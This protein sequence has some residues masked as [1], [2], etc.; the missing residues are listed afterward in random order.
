M[1]ILPTK[2]KYETFDSIINNIR[3][4][5]YRKHYWHFRTYYNIMSAP[6][7]GWNLSI[8]M[9]DLV[10]NSIEGYRL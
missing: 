1:R 5:L 9:E 4:E 7:S 10:M 6:E 3:D 8:E 2:F